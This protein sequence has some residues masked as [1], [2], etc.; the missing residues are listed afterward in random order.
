MEDASPLI[1]GFVADL[2]F[3]VKI[4][5][6]A[7]RLGF[8]VE[9]IEH[10][11]QIARGPNGEP[12]VRRQTAEHLAGPGAALIDRLT[13]WLPALII[14]DL[15][16]D[17][18]PWREWITLISSAPATRRIPILCFGSHVDVA[19]AQAAKSAGA[20]VVVARS[21]FASALPE[22]IEK[23]ARLLDLEG[24]QTACNDPL[25]QLALQGLHEFNQGE[26]FEAHE[27][28]EAAWNEDQSPAR[29]LYRALIQVAVAYLQIE[30][31]NYN[32]AAKMF[33]RMRQWLDPLPEMCRGVN[34]ERL[35]R[36]ARAA[37]Q[38]LLALGADHIH[39]FDQN[40]MKPVDYRPEP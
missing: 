40:L 28:L 22:L 9:W 24:I 27:I 7:Q 36:D 30:R 23:H 18:V 3:A 19:A 39:E 32:G 37:H 26:Y 17:G 5:E 8:R 11:G 20:K 35:R 15:N 25:S 12:A 16:N 13:R 4:E 38:A 10:A 14:F 29:D 1:V 6:A 31:G 2:M 21:R 34:I 33:L